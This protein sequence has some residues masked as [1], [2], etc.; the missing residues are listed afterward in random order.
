[1]TELSTTRSLLAP[2]QRCY[3]CAGGPELQ[4]HHLV[5][6]S[7]GGADGPTIM[8]CRDCHDS[9]TQERWEAYLDPTEFKVIDKETGEIIFQRGLGVDG[10]EA[11]DSLHLAREAL[12]NIPRF[13][14]YLDNEQLA[15]LFRE[16]GDVGK[17][18]WAAQAAIVGYAFSCRFVRGSRVQRLQALASE[19]RVSVGT[20]YDYAGAWLAFHER[21]GELVEAF[22][23]KTSYIIEAA[24]H[25]EEADE[26]IDEAIEQYQAGSFP[27]AAFR[28]HIR[29][30]EWEPKK[31]VWLAD[32]GL[33]C[34]RYQT[35]GAGT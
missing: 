13:I 21:L 11:F 30:E 29:G 18:G 31:C 20:V 34:D 8:L 19:L 1:M 28:A 4:E 32:D 23:G 33:R 9:F 35:T 25:P 5:N 2:N 26:L 12:E 16:L 24:R 3:L 6:R 27:L 15:A 7:Q 17:R 10:H 22:D 14:S